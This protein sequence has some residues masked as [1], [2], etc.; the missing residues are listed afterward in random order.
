MYKL[1][2]LGA[3]GSIEKHEPGRASVDNQVTISDFTVI[4]REQLVENLNVE[5]SQKESYCEE[6]KTEFMVEMKERDERSR[7]ISVGFQ[8]ANFN[9]L[10][11]L[12]HKIMGKGF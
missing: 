2:E 6:K 7:I 5:S 12:V 4:S 1:K 3:I 10:K 9:M 11:D 8:K